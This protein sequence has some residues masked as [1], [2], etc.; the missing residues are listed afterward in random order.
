MTCGS[1][2]CIGAPW[3]IGKREVISTARCASL[4]VR[5]RY[6]SHLC[7]SF[8]IILK[9]LQHRP[10][11]IDR[12]IY[13]RDLACDVAGEKQ[14]GICDIL[15][16]RYPSQGVISG[17]T[18]RGFLLTDPKSLCH[19][20]HYL[21][22]EPRAVH[23]TRRD[24]IHI[25]VVRADLKRK[26]LRD[27]AQSP[28][29]GRISHTTAAA[30]HAEGAAHIDDL[31]ITLPHHAREDRAHSIEASCHIDLDD[32][33]KLLARRFPSGLPDRPGS[34]RASDENIDAPKIGLGLLDEQFAL[35]GVGNVALDDDNLY[36]AGACFAGDGF[37][38]S[39]VTAGEREVASLRRK[40]ESDG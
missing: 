9:V 5:L 8:V 37:Y 22:A 12:K 26:R 1:P 6:H 19:F 32:L 28:F 27:A 35:T 30:A 24:A 13:A 18:L 2:M 20:G 11:A 16:G 14:T 23:H 3:N 36:V 17:M 40:G 33:L 15:V 7:A 39:Y 34:T 31:P 4:G 38:G 25:D 10:T 21:A 29:G